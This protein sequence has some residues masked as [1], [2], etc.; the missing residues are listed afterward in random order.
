M[1]VRIDI[2]FCSLALSAL[3]VD[4]ETK[5]KASAAMI[6]VNWWISRSIFSRSIMCPP[7]RRSALLSCRDHMH[8]SF[9]AAVPN[10][11]VPPM[12]R[13]ETRQRK[14]P[15]L[16][17]G[18]SWAMGYLSQGKENERYDKGSRPSVPPSARKRSHGT[19]DEQR[20]ERTQ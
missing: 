20:G 12:L 19:R 2:C 1:V 17:P 10:R 3:G 18:L 11:P 8:L 5:A 16:R 15:A 9:P 6:W 14:A 13:L 7:F 4:F